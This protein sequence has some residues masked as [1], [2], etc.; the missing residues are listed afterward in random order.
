MKK[1]NFIKVL[2]LL[3]IVL[4]LSV[5]SCVKETS[6]TELVVSYAD[7]IVGN[8]TSTTV[9]ILP[10][11]GVISSG[12]IT[13]TPANH[14]DTLTAVKINSNAVKLNYT[15]AYSDAKTH[16]FIDTLLFSGS[17]ISLTPYALGKIYNLDGSNVL[18][19]LDTNLGNILGTKDSVLGVLYAVSSNLKSNY[20]NKNYLTITG[21]F[22]LNVRIDQVKLR[23][24][25]GFPG[26]NGF[27]AAL[28]GIVKTLNPTWNFTTSATATLPTP[29]KGTVTSS[30]RR[31]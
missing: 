15:S 10:G 18:V 21:E 28:L 30:F 5:T 11:I 7:S 14:K 22:V 8:W 9:A 31:L 16:N 26:G 3:G 29:S 1:I 4:M 24:G 17:T 23:S 13:D 19:K 25:G 20:Y 2:T 6:N 12:F 27:Y